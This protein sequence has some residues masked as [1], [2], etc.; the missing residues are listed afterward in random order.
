[1]VKDRAKCSSVDQ[2]LD[3]VTS[4]PQGTGGGG[5][6]GGVTGRVMEGQQ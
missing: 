3:A 4:G 2:M 5:G 1:M 6:G